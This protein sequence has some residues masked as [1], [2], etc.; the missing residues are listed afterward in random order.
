MN[1]LEVIVL[2]VI[3]TF[4]ADVH[5]ESKT[6]LDKVN[7]MIEIMQVQK[8]YDKGIKSCVDSTL[9]AYYSP[10]KSFIKYG[11]YRGFKP[12]SK[13]WKKVNEIFGNYANSYCNRTSYSDLKNIYLKFFGE[14]LSEV[15][16]QNWIDFT[17]TPSG[18]AFLNIQDDFG[19][20]VN[21]FYSQRAD[22]SKALD[23]L[24]FELSRLA[25]RDPPDAFVGGAAQIILLFF[26]G[27][28]IIMFYWL[29]VKNSLIRLFRYIRTKFGKQN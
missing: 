7:Q 9:S 8:F 12:S 26:G 1:R 6:K 4:V 21:D 29:F 11:N 27:T 5:S 22:D 19:K 23:E 15:D 2:I 13:D 17:R 3:S 10:E 14:G 20:A 16:L 18:R 25:P 28:W 24:N